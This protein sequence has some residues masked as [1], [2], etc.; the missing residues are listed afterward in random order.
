MFKFALVLLFISLS[1]CSLDNRPSRS[2]KLPPGSTH[3]WITTLWSIGIEGSLK[4]SLLKIKIRLNKGPWTSW[5]T[6]LSSSKLKTYRP[7]L[8]SRPFSIWSSGLSWLK[9]HLTWTNSTSWARRST[10][11]SLWWMINGTSSVG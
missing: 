2:Y 8:K 4:T 1:T 11:L 3:S 5:A 6:N 9:S 10:W 7:T